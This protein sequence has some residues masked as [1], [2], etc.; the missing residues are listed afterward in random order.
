MDTADPPSSQPQLERSRAK[1]I[2]PDRHPL[3][4]EP[5]LLRLDESTFGD[6]ILRAASG[7]AMIGFVRGTGTL[8]LLE[9]RLTAIAREYRERAVVALV[10]VGE[11]ESLFRLYQVVSSPTVLILRR[12]AELG[13]LTGLRAQDQY[14][15]AL[16]SALLAPADAELIRLSD[17]N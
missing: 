10:D 1:C 14:S 17:S 6:S 2:V 7:V 16:D 4:L 11:A 8:Q 3:P 13:R 5:Q 12:G 15:L 9:I